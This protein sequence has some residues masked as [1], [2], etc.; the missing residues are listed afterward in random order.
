MTPGL[1]DGPTRPSRDTPPRDPRATLA[2]VH[3]F[4]YKRDFRT[5]LLLTAPRMQELEY[6]RTKAKDI[7]IQARN[8]PLR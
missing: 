3:P 8:A 5:S 7:S 6:G 2:W 4:L 1:A